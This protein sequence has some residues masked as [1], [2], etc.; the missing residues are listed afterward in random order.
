MVSVWGSRAPNNQSR[1]EEGARPTEEHEDSSVARESQEANEH[2]RLLPR[3]S[4]D[5]YLS[6]D[7]PAVS[8]TEHF[9]LLSWRLNKINKN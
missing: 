4:G 3:S 6:P 1:A 5:G 2:T 9:P 7:D 8:F